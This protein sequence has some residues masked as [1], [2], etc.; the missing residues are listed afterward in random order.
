MGFP[1]PAE[2]HADKPLHLHEYLIVHPAATF[3]WRYAGNTM[4]GAGIL[5]GALLIVDRSLEAQ[6]GDVV[7]A[8]HQGSRLV[9]RLRNKGRRYY[10]VAE[11]LNDAEIVT[12]VDEETIIWGVVTHVVNQLKAGAVR[13]DRYADLADGQG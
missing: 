2:D 9:R 10:L 4:N 5:S 7:A 12:E 3:F 1:S 6:P 11:P 8:Y 13:P